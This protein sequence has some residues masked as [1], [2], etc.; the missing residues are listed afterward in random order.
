M[1]IYSTDLH[2]NPNCIRLIDKCKKHVHCIHCIC[3]ICIRLF[4]WLIRDRLGFYAKTRII[5]WDSICSMQC[6]VGSETSHY[7]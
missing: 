1:K 7:R 2:C 6:E 3:I 4:L 5:F